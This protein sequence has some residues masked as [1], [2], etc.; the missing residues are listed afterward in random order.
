ME[1]S[2]KGIN[3]AL[4]WWIGLRSFFLQCGWNFER[5]QNLGW[6][7]CLWPALKRLYPDAEGRSG[8]MKRH[9]E[10]FNT[11]PYLASPILGCAIAAE[12][13]LARGGG[14]AV[15][16]EA[17][18]SSIKMGMMGPLAALGDR[19][20]WATLRP[21]AALTALALIWLLPASGGVTVAG[22]ALFL[23]LF[24]LPHLGIRFFGIFRGYRAGPG[25]IDFLR[26]LEVQKAARWMRR[27]GLLVLG[28]LL[29]TWDRSP[30]FQHGVHAA[31]WADVLGMALG[32][33]FFTLL[34]K[35]SS[36]TRA[37]LISVAV[38]FLAGFFLGRIFR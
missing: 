6:A 17:E 35:K 18:I 2:K 23:A 13:R 5:M 1:S 32:A 11:H 9:L 16:G 36:P 21:L 7:F 26:R 28:G 20:F 8:A 25:V 31:G 38:G 29:A 10:F 27:A 12:E 22:V 19:F 33:F 4:L 34:R 15:A 24:N 14:D 3:P 30:L 37:L